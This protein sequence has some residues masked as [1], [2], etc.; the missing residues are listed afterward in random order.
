MRRAP[1]MLLA[2]VALM[3][4][5]QTAFA[6]RAT[7][8]FKIEHKDVQVG[9]QSIAKANDYG[10]K[11]G[12]W[13]PVIVRF[14]ESEE[15]NI[16]LPVAEDGSISGEVLVE[17]A[18]ND[19][20]LNVYPQKFTIASGEP[21]QVVAY[22]KVAGY[23]AEVKI[24]VKAGGQTYKA[25]SDTFVGLEVGSH[26]YLTLNDTLP[27]L[28]DG[29]VQ[30]ANRPNDANPNR[31]TRPR[32][33]VYENDPK[34]L[35]ALWFGY[36][37]VD[38]AILATAND[39]FID[40]MIKDR[41]SSPQL[42]ALAEWVR[43]GG[44]LVVSVAPEHREKV[45]R[46]LTSPA[47][48][49]ALPLILPADSK[50]YQ[51]NTLDE[52]HDKD[53]RQWSQTNH[54]F[55]PKNKGKE[56]VARAVAL[57]SNPAVTVECWEQQ[58]GGDRVPLI[59]RFPYGLGFI[60]VI[61]FD[62]KEQFLSEWA[63]RNDFWKQ[64][65]LRNAPRVPEGVNFNDKF[66]GGNPYAFKDLTTELYGQLD[67]FD[68]PTISFGWVVLFIFLYI[69]VVGP[70]DY[71]ILK[72]LFKRLELTWLT[73]PAVVITIS[74]LAYFTA[75]AIKG[76]D[77]KVNKVDLIDIDL[78]TALK[79]DGTP[80]AARAYGTTW[81]S[82]L[83]PRIQNYT[84]GLEPSLYL[85]Q[86]QEPPAEPIQPTLSWLGRP[87]GGGMGASG[88]GRSTS[89]FSRTYSYAPNAT[90]LRDVPIPV[91]TIKSF[92]AAWEVPFAKLPFEVKLFHGPN[93]TL[94]GTVKNN[95][96]VHLKE[97]GLIYREQYHGLPDLPPGVAVPIVLDP[98]KQKSVSDWA[99]EPG[100]LG[101]GDF[102]GTAYNPRDVLRKLM[103][104]ELTDKNNLHGTNHVHRNLD[105]SWR[106]TDLAE[107]DRIRE[108][109]LVCRLTPRAKGP[110]NDLHASNDPRLATQLWLGELPGTPIPGKTRTLTRPDGKTEQVPAYVPRPEMQG[111]LVQDTFIR[112]LLPV[113]P[114][115][116]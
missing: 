21:L 55:R 48:K 90:G 44:R 45:H 80:T 88:R 114:K 113:V 67:K 116:D 70:V 69:L 59:L 74:L 24:S 10:F 63:G 115:K 102:D 13:T 19:G 35:P 37:P 111:T 103:F 52:W 101:S 41:Q 11:A 108:A 29:L 79:E 93:R 23:I 38:L 33:A 1:W 109:I 71:L 86:G 58:L 104:H 75:Y 73:F 107:D 22:T 40:K 96:S 72:L 99:K 91:W 97:C 98:I 36:N 51:L 18:D 42:E 25:L 94:T 50:A 12:L 64:V 26:I 4:A 76:Q 7:R 105:F 77:L 61:G 92:H 81:F 31:E 62:V 16:R 43:R 20:L 87:E 60:T 84:I 47:W 46:L 32:F 30:M 8:K 5:P 78:R 68:T 57:Q 6:Q 112:V 82:I 95:L 65:V 15:G 9:F 110:L 53:F 66:G 54:A 89:L 34:N 39:K 3:L 106:I 14:N 100:D 17:V 27:G 28:T 2:M 56:G 49:P 85:W 83:S